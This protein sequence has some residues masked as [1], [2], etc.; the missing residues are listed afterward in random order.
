MLIGY[1]RESAE[2][3]KLND[4]TDR[5]TRAGCGTVFKEA[6][7][8][9]RGELAKALHAVRF[10]DVLIVTSLDR[11]AWNIRELFQIV[12]K[13]AENGGGF[14]CLSDPWA[15]PA[16]EEGRH[17]L[18]ILQGLARFETV[19]FNDRMKTARNAAVAEG[20]HVGRRPKLS[21]D[22]IR[23]AKGRYDRGGITMAEIAAGYG[24]HVSLI[25][26]GFKKL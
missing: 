7:P 14:R 6:A 11:M 25:S 8:D 20:R 9:Q 22:Q 16:T 3:P 26:R 21:E 1:A 17:V 5:L 12:Q 10:G 24:V 19:A 4:Q 13:L 18:T 15:D 23:Y 2:G